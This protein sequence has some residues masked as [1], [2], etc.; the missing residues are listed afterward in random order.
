M[1]LHRDL[2]ITQKSAYFMSQRLRGAWSQSGRKFVSMAGSM[3]G[4]VEADETYI[5]GL[6]KN[7]HQS[8]KLNAGRGG[9]GKDIVVGIK[10][11]PS[12][13]VAAE[14]IP[15][16][17]AKTLHSFVE[18]HSHLDA[19]VYTDEGKGYLGMNRAH[20][21]VKHSVG[22]YVRGMAHTNGI[23]SFWAM[24]KRSHKG[25]FHKISPKHLQRYVDEFA[26]RHNLREQDTIKMMEET[27]AMMEGKRLTYQELIK[28]NG[29]SNGAR[30]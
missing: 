15:N 7:K 12:N 22:E 30:T 20:E 3:S 1:K 19:Q 16:T 9:T 6:E 8:K 17:K 14:V 23:E 29:L 13:K 18:Y 25:T 4:P 24:L 28:D 10:D 5:G 26:T 21:S 27:V 2:N 11:R